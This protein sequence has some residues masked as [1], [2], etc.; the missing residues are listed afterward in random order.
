LGVGTVA[1]FAAENTPAPQPAP[2]AEPARAQT[3]A[4][5]PAATP[6]PADAAPAWTFEKYNELAQVTGRKMTMSQGTFDAVQKR[7]DPAIARIEKYLAGHFGQADTR[8]LEA[9]RALPREYFHY[10]YEGK[11]STAASAYEIEPKPWGIGYG[12]ALSDYLG[13]AYMTQLG[14]PQPADVVLEIGT[15]SGF[16]SSLLSRLVK[17]VYTIEIIKPLG[18]SVAEVI[19][20]GGYDNVHQKVGDGYYGWPEVDGG[21]DIIMVTCAAL[22][23]PP[24]LIEQLKPGSGRLIIP[25]G[26]AIKGKQILYVYTKDGEGKVHSKRDVG[27]YFIPMTGAMQEKP[28]PAK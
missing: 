24:A 1:S 22:Y 4:P 15:G 19:K 8:V 10:N 9:F 17:E 16:Q 23:V 20:A 7:K 14:N 27:V 2:S 6:A 11:Y 28:K 12:S 21:F 18:E 25:V 3:P 13:Q 26:P 5:A